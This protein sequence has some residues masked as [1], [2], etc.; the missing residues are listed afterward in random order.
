ML[1]ENSIKWIK[2]HLKKEKNH[3]IAL[4]EVEQILAFQCFFFTQE[5]ES[6]AI[7]RYLLP[8]VNPAGDFEE[9]IKKENESI[10][11]VIKAHHESLPIEGKLAF[12]TVDFGEEWGTWH[13]NNTSRAFINLDKALNSLENSSM[14]MVYP[15]PIGDY[16]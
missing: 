12:I 1:T 3:K 10:N 9:L 5:R 6:R 16:S 11:A 14:G 4:D 7:L 8:S 13:C 2:F 15:V